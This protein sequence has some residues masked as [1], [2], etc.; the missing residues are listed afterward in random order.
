MTVPSTH[1]GRLIPTYYPDA[2]RRGASG[3]GAPDDVF[4]RRIT[5]AP[6]ALV[7]QVT[8]IGS[9]QA[10]PIVGVDK[11]RRTVTVRN[12]GGVDVY[13][14]FDTS[15]TIETGFRLAATDGPLILEYVGAVYAITPSG[16]AG[17]IHWMAETDAGV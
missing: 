8:N 17:V 4:V 14:G 3:P 7:G 15:V 6:T 5:G 9:T 11:H 16:A 2:D 10:V 1:E 12:S 13:I